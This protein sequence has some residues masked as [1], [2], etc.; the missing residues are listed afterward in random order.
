MRFNDFPSSIRALGSSLI[1]IL[2]RDMPRVLVLIGLGYWMLAPDMAT[3][4]L[5]RYSFGLALFL[6]A[7]S[8]LTRRLL[9]TNIDLQD[10]LRKARDGSLGAA[11]GAASVCAVLIALMF[12]MSMPFFRG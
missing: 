2:V 12:I 3:L 9:F 11:V 7:A 4:T 8:H 5:I 1:D 6:V 10:M